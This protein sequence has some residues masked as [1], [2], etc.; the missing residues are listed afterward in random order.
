M[1]LQTWHLSG[2][3]R[4]LLGLMML[5]AA[6]LAACGGGGGGGGSSAPPIQNSVAAF[7]TSDSFANNIK[8]YR[9]PAT[10][11][12]FKLT[13]ERTYQAGDVPIYMQ[14]ITNQCYYSINESSNNIGIHKL[15][16]Q[17]SVLETPSFVAT[18]Q[19]PFQSSIS[20]DNRHLYVTNS[21]SNSI[22]VYAVN[23][24][25]CGLTLIQTLTTTGL[26]PRDIV[27]YADNSFLVAH[28]DSNSIQFYSRNT[29]TGVLTPSAQPQPV[30]AEP[31]DIVSLALNPTQTVFLVSNRTGD[32]VTKLIYDST[33]NSFGS[34]QELATGDGTQGI[35]IGRLSTDKAVAYVTNRIANTVQ[36]VSM[37]LVN[38]ANLSLLGSA[39]PSYS[40]P[41]GI[42][43]GNSGSTQSENLS[44][45]YAFHRGT[46]DIR[47]YR[48]N[49]TTGTLTDLGSAL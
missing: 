15:N 4:G 11:N 37:D 1:H 44:V 43:F 34:I 29:V 39:L 28:S 3:K 24:A 36:A 8:L 41:Y 33:T 14:S 13:L 27:S 19:G 22:T 7:F 45:I 31:V 26:R 47:A 10:D 32:S 18:G 5:C 6:L 40:L 9:Y 38:N 2:V 12:E 46:S 21:I 49:R 23:L 25:T 17:T 20:K 48:V 30:G 16:T 35:L 42:T